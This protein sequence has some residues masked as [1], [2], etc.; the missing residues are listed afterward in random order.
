MTSRLIDVISQSGYQTYR[1]S[2]HIDQLLWN[3]RK[4]HHGKQIEA[5]K[6]RTAAAMAPII[7]QRMREM[8]SHA[9]NFQNREKPE[10]E[11]PG[12]RRFDGVKGHH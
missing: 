10:S 5:L 4:E 2:T 3:R 1:D 8:I 6:A 7:P 11:S 9:S 12:F